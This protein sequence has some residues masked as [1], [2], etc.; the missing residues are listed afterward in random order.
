MTDN[1]ADDAVHDV[2]SDFS[3]AFWPMLHTQ[4]TYRVRNKPLRTRFSFLPR[5]STRDADRWDFILPKRDVLHMWWWP[6]NSYESLRVLKRE[7]GIYSKYRCF[8]LSYHAKGENLKIPSSWQTGYCI[9][10]AES[11]DLS[12]FTNSRKNSYTSTKVNLSIEYQICALRR[13]APMIRQPQKLIFLTQFMVY[14]SC[15]IKPKFQFL[16]F[17]TNPSFLKDDFKLLV[18]QMD[19]F[20]RPKQ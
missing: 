3:L 11:S 16:I 20:G 13:Y 2:T 1:R 7:L 9:I 19:D 6:E 18:I 15:Y 5:Q 10:N 8:L 12:A 14:R 17:R 4:M